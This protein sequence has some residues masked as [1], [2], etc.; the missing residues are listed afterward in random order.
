MSR[1]ASA[2]AERP[3]PRPAFR[4]EDPLLLDDQLDED[5]RMVR[6][7]ARAYCQDK[8]MPRVLEANRNEVF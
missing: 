1:P 2:P 4:W 7:S 5:E 8:L 3:T 6:D